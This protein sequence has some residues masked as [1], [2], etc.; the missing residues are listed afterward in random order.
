MN[1]TDRPGRPPLSPQEGWISDGRQVLHF[2]PRRYDRWSQSLEVTLGELIPGEA[3]PLLKR[4]KELTREQAMKLW[5]QKRRAGPSGLPPE[6]QA[7][8]VELFR[9]ANTHPGLEERL[10][11]N[12]LLSLPPVDPAAV[13][14]RIQADRPRWAEMVQI[15]GARIE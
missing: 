3:A 4:R 7:R 6:L 15:S 9:R 14:A 13:R 10:R 5:A 1:V 2:Q 8:T 11:Q 12:G